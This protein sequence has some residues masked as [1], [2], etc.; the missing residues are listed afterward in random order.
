MRLPSF[1]GNA[2]DNGYDEQEILCES[3]HKQDVSVLI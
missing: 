1:D 3:S 2:E